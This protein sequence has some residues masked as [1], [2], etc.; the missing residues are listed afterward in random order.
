M[1]DMEPLVSICCLTYNHAPF[2]R[3]CLDGFLMQETSFPVEILIHDDA[4]TDGTDDIVREY[5]EK[6]PEKIFPLFET[7]NKYS[8]GYKGRMD[9]TFNYSRARGKYI[10]SCEGDDYWTDPLKL[11]KQVDFMESHP[12]YSVCFHRYK[13]YYT[14]ADLYKEDGCAELFAMN[15]AYA[16]I[17]IDDFFHKWV[18]QPLTMLFRVSDFSFDWQPMYKNYR[19]SYEIYHL[20][21][22]GKSVVMNFCGG[23]YVQQKGGIYTSHSEAV[24]RKNSLM[25]ARELY[26]VNNDAP[27]KRNYENVL[28]WYL[29]NT[30]RWGD[31]RYVN[32]VRLL[33]LNKNIRKFIRNVIR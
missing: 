2:I 32:A 11:Q 5:A 8:N 22:S 12:D 15:Q 4:S 25:I 29:Y 26:L 23:V 1:N 17:S 21:K 3:K 30:R 28:Q 19:D 7:E 16:T 9:T 14:E 27:T 33:I 24:N 6:Y 18:T 10:A 20:L 13:F 31:R